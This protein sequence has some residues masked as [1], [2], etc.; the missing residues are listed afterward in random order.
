MHLANR[1]LARIGARGAGAR[2]RMVHR[3][4]GRSQLPLPLADVVFMFNPLAPRALAKVLGELRALAEGGDGRSI[5]DRRRVRGEPRSYVAQGEGG[6]RNRKC[7]NSGVRGGVGGVGGGGF[8]LVLKAMDAPLRSQPSWTG[9]EPEAPCGAHAEARSEAQSEAQSGK[10]DST[11]GSDDRYL[12]Q[13]ELANRTE[14]ME[15]EMAVPA[16]CCHPSWLRP[17]SPRVLG[18]PPGL[19]AYASVARSKDGGLA[20]VS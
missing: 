9:L 16:E 3:T 2:Q 14:Q 12:A 10:L 5:K 4:L 18:L 6:G 13:H 7:A 20:V 11:Q 15:I 1:A 17:L 8:I 19:R